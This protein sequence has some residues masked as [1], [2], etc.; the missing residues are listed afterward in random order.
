MQGVFADSRVARIYFEE[1]RSLYAS[2]ENEEALR[3]L[4]SALRFRPAYAD[5]LLLQSRLLAENR[6]KRRSALDA[7]RSAL[8]AGGWEFYSPREA[9]LHLCGLLVDMKRYGEALSLLDAPAASVPPSAEEY[10]LRLRCYRGL[11]D[12][13]RLEAVLEAALGAFPGES[14]FLEMFFKTADP[15]GPLT[16]TSFE[17]LYREPRNLPVVAAYILA[18]GD[19]DAVLRLAWDYFRAGGKDPAVSCLLIEKGLVDPAREMERFIVF[20]GLARVELVRKIAAALRV[21][22]PRLLPEALASFTGTAVL[23]KDG[24]GIPEEMFRVGKGRLLGWDT[25]EDQDGM[26]EVSVHFGADF[27]PDALFYR[28]PDSILRCVFNGYPYVS[29]GSYNNIEGEKNIEYYLL[30]GT[31]ALP[32]IEGA[33]PGEEVSWLDY[34]LNKDFTT[35]AWEKVEAAASRYEESS[36]REPASRRVVFLAEGRARQIDIEYGGI[37]IHR[38]FFDEGRFSYGLRDLDRDGVFDTREFYEDGMLAALR[39]DITGDGKEDYAETFFPDMIKEWD[40]DGDGII[41]AREARGDAGDPQRY[42]KD[43]GGTK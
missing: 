6:E 10:K 12:S 26:Y 14:F 40:I 38:L 32:L 35:L 27:L 41:D 11:G 37:V 42:Y 25:D 29:T 5:A 19:S 8:E 20:G 21:R 23:D 15:L 7:A 31:L 13:K 30:P 33:L 4:D 39:A 16:V 2:G 1:A 24:D 34:R 3:L 43:F 9:A 36:A 22:Y 18:A 28:Q 17:T